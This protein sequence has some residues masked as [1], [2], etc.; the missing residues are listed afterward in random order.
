MT[1]NTD[2]MKRFM[3]RLEKSNAGQEKYAKLQYRMSQ[4]TAE[5]SGFLRPASILILCIVLYT[6][7]TVIPRVNTL[8][9][10][11]QASVS[12]IQKISKD[13]SDA[14]LPEMI[15]NMDRLVTTSESS[16][17]TA[18]EK[19]NSIDFDS[20]NSAIRDLANIVRPLGKLFGG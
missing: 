2:E 17:E 5:S 14:N 4:L 18:V 9:N 11:I 16:I 19:L 20:L 6:A 1:G 10:D 12:N 7:A 15:D 8:F 13:L 3:E